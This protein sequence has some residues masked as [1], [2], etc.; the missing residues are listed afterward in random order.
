M[1]RK[2]GIREKLPTGSPTLYK[3]QMKVGFLYE[4]VNNKKSA[5]EF[6]S[7]AYKN[8]L[9]SMHILRQNY[10]LWEIKAVADAL[11]IKS[12]QYLVDTSEAIT[13]KQIMCN[14][15]TQLKQNIEKA[16]KTLL[17]LVN[18]ILILYRSIDG[19]QC[20]L[21]DKLYF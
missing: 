2:L 10:D 20:Y 9:A 7:Q 19:V 16:N 3:L 1:K 13:I 8:F 4:I 12:A 5:N 6:F 14:H 18:I 11:M 21:I 17:F 15:F